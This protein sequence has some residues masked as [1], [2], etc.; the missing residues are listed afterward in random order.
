MCCYSAVGRGK[1]AVSPETCATFGECALHLIVL[2]CL[3]LHLGIHFT[4]LPH[5]DVT[6]HLT[7]SYAATAS[8]A[9]SLVLNRELVKPEWLTEVIRLAKDTEISYVPPQPSKFRPG[10]APSLP[11]NQRDPRIWDAN[12]ERLAM[13][14]NYRFICVTDNSREIDRDLR[15]LLD[16]SKAEVDT[17]N[18]RDGKAKWR[19]ALSRASA[20]QGKKLIAVADTVT[21]SI[22]VGKHEWKELTDELN[23]CVS[24]FVLSSLNLKLTNFTVDTSCILFL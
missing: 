15:S 8:L 10:F 6:H 7:P 24:S 9:T 18:A 21:M 16:E 11:K 1:L 5:S 22:A 19:K 14:K 2:L 3:C 23:L 13:F 17:F 12:E 4:L 20:K